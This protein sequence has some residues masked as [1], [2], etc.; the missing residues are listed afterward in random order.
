MYCIGVL[1]LW[2][3]GSVITVSWAKQGFNVICFDH[4]KKILNRLRKGKPAIYEPGLEESFQELINE[5]KIQ[6]ATNINQLSECNFVFLTYDTPVNDKDE[7]DISILEKSVIGLGNIMKN[8]SC[9]II[10]SQSPLGA[11]SYLRGN[12]RV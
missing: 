6:I 12:C 11:C 9:L 10:S 5:N 8:S 4:D 7:S 2:H 3:L 1:G